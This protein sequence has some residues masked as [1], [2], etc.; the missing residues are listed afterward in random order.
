MIT[1][2]RSALAEAT[3][4]Y[5]AHTSRVRVRPTQRIIF[6]TL[7]FSISRS[8]IGTVSRFDRRSVHRPRGFPVHR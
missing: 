5:A 8:E 7:A 6:E 2:Q 3:A 4:E 1:A